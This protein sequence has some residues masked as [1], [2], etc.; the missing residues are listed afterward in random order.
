MHGRSPILCWGGGRARAAP[1]STPMAVWVFLRDCASASFGAVAS[2]PPKPM[3]HI[4]PYFHK[5]IPPICAKLSFLLPPLFDHDAFTLYALCHT[6][7]GRL[8][9]GVPLNF[10]SVCRL[11]LLCLDS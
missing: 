8:W 10:Q 7:T 3:M 2:I 5:I 11:I 1:K 9:F 4:H 6:R